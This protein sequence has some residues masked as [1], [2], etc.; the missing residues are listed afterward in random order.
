MI[1]THFVDITFVDLFLCAHPSTNLTSLVV[2]NSGTLSLSASYSLFTWIA[3]LSYTFP[4]TV[5][6][7]FWFTR[8]HVSL[9]V[10]IALDKVIK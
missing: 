1:S 10:N 3:T 2:Y 9:I 5:S 4:T 7:M 6:G 8:V